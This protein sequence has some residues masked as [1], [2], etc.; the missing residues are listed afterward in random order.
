V[1]V[2]VFASFPVALVYDIHVG[3]CLCMREEERKRVC[4]CVRERESISVC[5]RFCVISGLIDLSEM[6]V[7]VCMCVRVCMLCVCVC[8]C[9]CV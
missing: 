8:V 4:V 6:C 7:C 1:S 9:V 3:A 2:S 5:V